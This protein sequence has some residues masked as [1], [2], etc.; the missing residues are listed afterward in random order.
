MTIP[1]VR[2]ITALTWTL[3]VGDVQRFSSINKAI[4]Y[5]GLCGAEKSSGSTVQRQT[6]LNSRDVLKAVLSRVSGRLLLTSFS[7][8]W[9][10]TKSNSLP[11]SDR[12]QP[13]ICCKTHLL[14]ISLLLS[15]PSLVE[16]PSVL[17]NFAPPYSVSWF[18][19]SEGRNWDLIRRTSAV[20]GLLFSDNGVNQEL[21]SKAIQT[22]GGPCLSLHLSALFLAG[23]CRGDFPPH[24][25]RAMAATSCGS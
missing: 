6:R 11:P 2:P 4:S 20:L 1:A 17:P 16:R 8:G 9:A 19:A 7:S 13:A 12:V 10:P 24:D 23:Q 5:C 22:P 14:Q 18:K 21:L 15:V 3:E 25:R